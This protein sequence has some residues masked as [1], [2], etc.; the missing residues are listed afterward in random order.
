MV[1]LVRVFG[2][3]L[4]DVSGMLDA[5][6]YHPIGLACRVCDLEAKTV[7]SS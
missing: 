4:V 6:T 7:A 2:L 3:D 5:E 1:P